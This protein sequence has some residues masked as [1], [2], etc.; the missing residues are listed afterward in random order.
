MFEAEEMKKHYVAVIT[1]IAFLSEKVTESKE[2]AFD[3]DNLFFRDLIRLSDLR[4]T[5]KELYKEAFGK[6]VNENE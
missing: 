1:H 6:E 4:F 5:L 3:E 2:F